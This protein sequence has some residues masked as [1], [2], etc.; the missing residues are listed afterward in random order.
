MPIPIAQV[1]EGSV[2]TIEA[3][4]GITPRLRRVRNLQILNVQVR[5]SSGT[6][7]LTWFNMPFLMNRLAKGKCYL[8]RGK[9]RLKNGALVMEAED[10]YN[11]DDY[12]KLL[13]VLANFP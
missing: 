5:D 9:V 1:S 13:K 3:Y 2:A 11:K 6:L 7:L 4:L 8:F 12:Y 10:F